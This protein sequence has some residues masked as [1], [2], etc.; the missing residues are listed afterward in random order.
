MVRPHLLLIVL[1]TITAATACPQTSNKVNICQ[2]GVNVSSN[3]ERD[4]EIER[5][6]VEKK[7]RKE[8]A[9]KWDK[10]NIGFI[11]LA[12]FAAVGLVITGIGVSRSNS[13]LNKSSEELS[14]AKDLKAD[15]EIAAVN[16]LASDANERAGTLEKEA[17]QLTAGNLRLEAAIAPRRLS[18][19]Q[20]KALSALT[21]FAGRPVSITSYSSDTEGLILAAQIL[22]GL[23]KSG[24]QIQDNRLT[25][26]PAGS[27]SFGVSVAGT[28]RELVEELRGI[29][30]MDGNLTT[31]G[32][33]GAPNRIGLSITGIIGRIETP[34]PP[35][36]IITVGVKPIK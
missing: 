12:G 1:T 14:H 34:R 36:A 23:S 13:L 32:S 7:D 2:K 8:R 33:I 21:R 5:L 24:L 22:D 26:Q 18:A 17:A 3:I 29:L 4:I 6:I 11:F 35:V 30:A 19:R 10:Y 9:E 16:C 25:M 27:V 20:D 15:G 31:T 28:D